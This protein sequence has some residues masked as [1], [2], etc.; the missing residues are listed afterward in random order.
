MTTVEPARGGPVP[1]IG[2][3]CHWTRPLQT[4]WSGTP[5]NLRVEMAAVSQVVDVGV[6]LPTVT[7]QVLK[8]AY[9]RRGAG[10]WRSS[11]R[12]GLI[13]KQLA[14][15]AIRRQSLAR[16]VDAVLEVQDLGPLPVPF[17]VLQDLSYALLLE[18]HGPDGVPHFRDVP[19]RR[20]EALRRRQDRVYAEA[21]MLLPMSR[22]LRD[23]LVA[24]GVPPERVRVVN[25]GSDAVPA[26]GTAVPERRT[27]PEHRLLFVGRDFDTKGGAQ[28]VAAFRLLRRELGASVTLTVA[29]PDRWPLRGPVPE[30][31]TFLGRV[32]HQ[33][34]G[35]LMD[36]AD[37]LVM[38]SQLEGFGIVFAEALS[39]GLPCVGRDTCA[40]PEIIDP[41]SGGRLVRS[42]S[43]DELAD[44]VRDALADDDLYARCA[45]EADRRREH[46][47]W[48]RAAR[49]VV[50]AVED[51]VSGVPTPDRAAG[52]PGLASSPSGTRRGQV[53]D[54]GE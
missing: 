33:T 12:Q 39:R 23:S 25:P 50:S 31:I 15:T 53:G 34:V 2:F 52:L 26:V 30:G 35:E 8:V 45:A 36:A 9:A 41:A 20:L 21:A 6:E 1:R 46:Y 18:R 32:A 38:P 54:R 47:T 49:E 19:R 22:W 43:P 10:R 4:S 44:L 48:R 40:M 29:G 51:V 17:L 14:Q 37:L 7:R 27:R 28:V 11:W 42:E 13:T 16:G 3:A 5:W 24:G